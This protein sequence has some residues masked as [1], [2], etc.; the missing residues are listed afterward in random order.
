MY[1]LH[2]LQSKN[3]ALPYGISIA[4]R[5]HK[6]PISPSVFSGNKSSTGTA[7]GVR[8]R[9]RERERETGN[10]VSAVFVVI[11]GKYA[12]SNNQL[13]LPYTKPAKYSISGNI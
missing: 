3:I 5:R 13:H 11:R 12:L 4:K 8:K 6:I 7:V 2:F 9:E 1:W 10:C